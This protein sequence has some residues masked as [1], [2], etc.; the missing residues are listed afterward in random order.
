L[1]R[2]IVG[3]PCPK[4]AAD[5]SREAPW[6]A[7]DIRMSLRMH[8]VKTSFELAKKQGV[9]KVIFLSIDDSFTEDVQ[10]WGLLRSFSVF[11]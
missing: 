2:H 11:P 5:T 6:Q 8:L 7:D 1:Y 10:I 9:S 3:D 4:S